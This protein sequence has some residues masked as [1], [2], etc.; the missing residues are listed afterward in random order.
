MKINS[1]F[2]IFVKI[3]IFIIP[4]FF[5]ISDY[6]IERFIFIKLYFS[7]ICCMLLVIL[8]LSLA[9]EGYI[10]WKIIKYKK[11]HQLVKA[12]RSF[13]SGYFDD[14]LRGI[15]NFLRYSEEERL[16]L[17]LYSSSQNKFYSVGRYSKSAKFNNV[18]RYVIDDENEY[19]YNVINEQEEKH[20]TKSPSI[21]SKKFNMQSKSMY[22]V[23]IENK[24][25]KI[26]VVIAQSMNSDFWKSKDKRRKLKEKVCSLQNK[27]IE[28]NINPNTLP[29]EINLSEKGL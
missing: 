6:L 24:G 8:F 17:F 16:T 18:G 11:N 22:G 23:P 4:I 15:F 10:Q 9:M 5:G 21:N 3:S 2:N 26:A 20:N 29:S 1:I 28:M 14:E 13:I 12:Y 27:M 7:I 19:V 25:I